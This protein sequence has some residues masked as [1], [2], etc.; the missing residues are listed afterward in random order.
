[1]CDFGVDWN[2]LSTV[3]PSQE[4]LLKVKEEEIGADGSN[5]VGEVEEDKKA[6]EEKGEEEKPAA[7][8]DKVEVVGA[9]PNKEGGE[10]ENPK[11]ED[12][13]DKDEVKFVKKADFLYPSIKK[14]HITFLSMETKNVVERIFWQPKLTKQCVRLP[15]LLGKPN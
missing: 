8:E 15:W 7:D 6:D 14:V 4:D 1:M 12:I 10:A 13:K 2:L 9:D 3:S 11:S 5:D